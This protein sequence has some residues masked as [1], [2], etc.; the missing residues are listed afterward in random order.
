MGQHLFDATDCTR[1]IGGIER[2]SG[3]VVADVGHQADTFIG[4]LEGDDIG[5]QLGVASIAK[6]SDLTTGQGDALDRSSER[7]ACKQFACRLYVL[8]LLP[9]RRQAFF[10]ENETLGGSVGAL[11]RPQCFG[12]RAATSAVGLGTVVTHIAAPVFAELAF[13]GSAD[14]TGQWR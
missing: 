5:G 11:L 9:C 3:D 14:T 2:Q 10:T 4:R 8:Q 13:S 6:G 12:R 1:R 7:I